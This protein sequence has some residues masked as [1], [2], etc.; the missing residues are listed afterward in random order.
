MVC[1]SYDKILIWLSCWSACIRMMTKSNQNISHKIKKNQTIDIFY[2]WLMSTTTNK[3][4]LWQLWTAQGHNRS[5]QGQQNLWIRYLSIANTDTHRVPGYCVRRHWH[6]GHAWVKLLSQ[7]PQGWQI[8]VVNWPQL[9]IFSAILKVEL[10]MILLE[11]LT[12]SL[13]AHP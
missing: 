8:P 5:I 2:A 7:V 4:N 13:G 1:G 9:C 11:L 6:Q 12:R 3:T 10:W